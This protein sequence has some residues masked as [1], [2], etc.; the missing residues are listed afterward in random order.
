[1]SHR[2]DFIRQFKTISDEVMLQ[3]NRMEMP[4]ESQAI[5]DRD[6]FATKLITDLYNYEMRSIDFRPIRIPSIKDEII[7]KVE[8]MDNLAT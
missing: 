6:N 8:K 7:I 5:Q 4:Y 3:L 1:M 2:I